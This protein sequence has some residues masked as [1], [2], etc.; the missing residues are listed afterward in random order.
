[1]TKSIFIPSGDITEN[2]TAK[3][4]TNYCNS[5][6]LIDCKYFIINNIQHYLF[7]TICFG[8]SVIDSLN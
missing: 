8:L 2:N 7:S 6:Y 4:S 1:M 5:N 3:Y